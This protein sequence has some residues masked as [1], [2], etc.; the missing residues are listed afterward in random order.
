MQI[1][2]KGLKFPL[3]IRYYTKDGAHLW[4]KSKGDHVKIGMDAFAAEITNPLNVIIINKGQFKKGDMIGSFESTKY[5]GRLYS[6]INGEIIDVNEKVMSN[7]QNI[8]KNPYNSWIA[9]MKPDKINDKDKYIIEGKEKIS[10]W[11]NEEIKRME[12]DG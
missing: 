1:E 3:D 5:I 12:C 9:E 6:P 7:P 10:K 11:I 8:N 4:L 2:I